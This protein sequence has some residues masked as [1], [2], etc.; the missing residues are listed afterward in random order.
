ME[1]LAL[2]KPH[3]V[4]KWFHWLV[5]QELEKIWEILEIKS[6]QLDESQIRE[7]YS[8]HVEQYYFEERILWTFL[9]WRTFAVKL[10]TE[11]NFDE[12]KDFKN[13]LREKYNEWNWRNALHMS[14]SS[15]DARRELSILFTN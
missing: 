14:S 15:E 5:K 8:E 1:I 11:M 2:I 13:A 4:A 6:V 12:L 3:I 10:K 9:E 7:I